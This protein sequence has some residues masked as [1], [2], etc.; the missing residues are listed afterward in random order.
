MNKTYNQFLAFQIEPL[1]LAHVERIFYHFPNVT[2]LLISKGKLEMSTDEQME[3]LNSFLTR[4]PTIYEVQ[5]NFTSS[6]KEAVVV[7]S[8]FLNAF[9][10]WNVSIYLKYYDKTMFGCVMKRK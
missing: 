9:R 8:A 7:Y 1:T 4:F 2:S 6:E 5:F 3:E 10:E